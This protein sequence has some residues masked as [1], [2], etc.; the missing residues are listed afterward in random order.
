M[1]QEA[2]AMS[3][4]SE[5]EGFGLNRTGIMLNPEQSA[6]LI[7]G[8]KTLAPRP[9]GED[10]NAIVDRANYVH[11]AMPIGSVPTV[12]DGTSEIE[13]APGKTTAIGVLLDKLGERLAFERQG[14]RLYQAFLE[15]LQAN[16]E[17]ASGPSAEDLSHIRDEEL[18]HFQLLQH[19]I[20]ELGGDPTVQTPSADVA[21]VLSQGV[22]QIVS[23]PRT[24]IAQTLQAM[25]NAELADNDGWKM[26]AYM[27]ANMGHS[28]LAEKCEEAFEQ[29][30]EHLE[31][32]RAW[33]TETTLTEVTEEGSVVQGDRMGSKRSTRPR[34]SRRGRTAKRRKK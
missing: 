24:S 31:N 13:P 10:G 6:E 21:G 29:E 4:Q 22:F 30:Q 7:E 1:T 12:I 20:D 15:K 32:V 34:R 3:S 17:I 2:R 8:A 28:E 11:E 9:A 27:T 25:L 19:A 14:T 5:H 18:E 23:D 16:P 33:L 26:L